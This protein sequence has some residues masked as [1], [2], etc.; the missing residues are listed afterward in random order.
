MLVSGSEYPR[1]K[2]GQFSQK[3]LV[4]LGQLV[5]NSESVRRIFSLLYFFLHMKTLSVEMTC[6]LG[7][8]NEIEAV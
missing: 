4:R 5:G 8:Q 3:R 1:D 2:P 6:P 7:I